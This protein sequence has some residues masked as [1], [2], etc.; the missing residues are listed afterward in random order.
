VDTVDGAKVAIKCI[1]DVFRTT[2]DAKR[3]L[4]R[5]A[6]AASFLRPPA[7]CLRGTPPDDRAASLHGS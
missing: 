3:T 2:E 5:A 4:V 7:H 6:A 1:Q